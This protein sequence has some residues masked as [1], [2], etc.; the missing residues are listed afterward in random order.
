MA[1]AESAVALE[2]REWHFSI[3]EFWQMGEAGLFQ[4]KKTEL[5]FGKV[6]RMSPTGS[7][8]E[9]A[10]LI[11]GGLLQSTIGE[12]F[13]VRPQLGLPVTDDTEVYPDIAVVRGKPLDYLLQKPTDALLVIEIS[14]TSLR[15]DLGVKARIYA[16]AGIQEYWVLDLVHSR[17]IVHRRPN[18]DSAATNQPAYQ[19]VTTLLPDDMVEPLAF[20]GVQFRVGDMLPMVPGGPP[21][22][23]ES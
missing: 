20:P 16:D 23:D 7:R 13:L 18:A 3:E 9:V 10:Q 8:H 21:E 22:G 17:L 2:P 1:I 19:S 11:L 14:D 6:V 12:E 15:L 5:I 4:D